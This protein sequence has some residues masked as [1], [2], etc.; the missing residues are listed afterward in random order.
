MLIQNCLKFE[1]NFWLQNILEAGLDTLMKIFKKVK[2]E[3][4]K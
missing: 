3:F 2:K 4:L 1:K